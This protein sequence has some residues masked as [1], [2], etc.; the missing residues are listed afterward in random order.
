MGMYLVTSGP[1]ARCGWQLRGGCGATLLIGEPCLNRM[2]ALCAIA[3]CKVDAAYPT[4]YRR[5]EAP[6]GGPYFVVVSQ[7]EQVIAA[8]PIYRSV[9]DRDAAM[10]ACMWHGPES[11]IEDEAIESVAR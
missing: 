11:R 4:R 2:E 5:R 10:A 9:G 6:G 3:R 7:D 1:G 8:S